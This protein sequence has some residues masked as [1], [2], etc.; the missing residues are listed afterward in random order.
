MSDAL[1]GLGAARKLDDEPPCQAVRKG[2]GLTAKPQRTRRGMLA[3]G[4]GRTIT[5]SSCPSYRSFTVHPIPIPLSGRVEHE[6]SKF[7]AIAFCVEVVVWLGWPPASPSRAS[8]R[9]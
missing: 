3:S 7:K 8:D 6:N 5:V 2:R 1:A 4:D 9:S